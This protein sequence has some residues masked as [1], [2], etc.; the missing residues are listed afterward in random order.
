METNHWEIQYSGYYLRNI[1]ER[2]QLYSVMCSKVTSSPTSIATAGSS[3]L[4]S[5]DSEVLGIIQKCLLHG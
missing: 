3:V 5:Y 4:L 2:I 1:L